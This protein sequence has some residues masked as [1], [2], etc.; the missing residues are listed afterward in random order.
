MLPSFQKR[1][2][3]PAE[4]NA[5]VEWGV[6]AHKQQLNIT[7]RLPTEKVEIHLPLP[8]GGANLNSALYQLPYD[9]HD[10]PGYDN[11][12]FRRSAL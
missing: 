6:C 9:I 12:L 2:M 4:C 8:K 5:A 11:N 3:N 10:L 1:G 7:L